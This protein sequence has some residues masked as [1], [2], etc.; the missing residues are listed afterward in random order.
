MHGGGA[1]GT[2]PHHHTAEVERLLQVVCQQ[3]PLEA[4][5]PPTGQFVT[6]GQGQGGL[7][8]ARLHPQNPCAVVLGPGAQGVRGASRDALGPCS[9]YV[10]TWWWF[11]IYWVCSVLHLHTSPFGLWWGVPVR[12]L[13]PLHVRDR[14]AG[15]W[16]G[17]PVR[18]VQDRG[19][20]LCHGD[21]R[22]VPT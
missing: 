2:P 4:H 6:A 7:P 17:V 19:A 3:R 22:S 10:C 8:S 16:W 13:E 20:G 9:V 5:Y 14:R 11:W 21:N 1:V 18:P 12:P 15:L